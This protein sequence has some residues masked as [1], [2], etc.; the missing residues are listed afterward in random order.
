[1]QPAT[2]VVRTAGYDF[3]RLDFPRIEAAF[4]A[5]VAAGEL[6]RSDIIAENCR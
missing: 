3:D 5:A 1:M 4:L 6:L 2:L